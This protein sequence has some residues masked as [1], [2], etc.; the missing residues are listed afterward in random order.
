[1]MMTDNGN[2]EKLCGRPTGK[3]EGKRTGK[4]RR[5]AGRSCSQKWEA[6]ILLC[7]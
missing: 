6:G 3:M 7:W 2:F 4:D 1:M 5:R